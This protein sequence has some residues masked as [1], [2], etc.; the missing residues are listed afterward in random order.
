MPTERVAAIGLGSN[1]GDRQG[2]L[3]A[4]LARLDRVEGIRVIAT[5]GIYESEGW[6]RPDLSPFLN[7]AAA[8]RTTL[9][10]VALLR[11]MLAVEKALGR[12]RREKWAPRPIDLDLLAVE[13]LA[14]ESEELKLPHPWI[15]K[16]PFVYIPLRD[17]ADSYPGWSPLLEGDPEGIEIEKDTVRTDYGRPVW[18]RHLDSIEPEAT[19]Q[20]EGEE[21]TQSFAARLAAYLIPG[22]D[23]ALDA[24]M[25]A[26][27][28]VFARG[29]A[30]GLGVTGPVQSPT[31]TLCRTYETERAILEH[32][33]FYRLESEDDLESTGFF[34]SDRK[35]TIRVAE[36]ADHFPE[37]L[38]NAVLRARI[39]IIDADRRRIT[40]SAGN[41][42]RLLFPMHALA[43]ARECVS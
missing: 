25:G 4:A 34:A 31:F 37:A 22:E 38:D 2:Y 9:E 13:D 19:F 26:G 17:V 43:T 36:W 12:Q 20:S 33:D 30:R 7:A 23:I 42:D 32:W 39:D 35:H 8:V 40:L 11:A 6:G 28:S 15:R 18:A 3:D 21:E 16:R 24:P 1:M 14:L 41:R 10:P 29:I 27:K 5:S